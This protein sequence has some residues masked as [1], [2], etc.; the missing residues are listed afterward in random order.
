MKNRFDDRAIAAAFTQVP[1]FIA[2]F[3]VALIAFGLSTEL[4]DKDLITAL[5][6][7]GFGLYTASATL[8][9]ITA[10]VYEGAVL[11]PRFFL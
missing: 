6:V 5:L 1:G 10:G 8:S 3:S 7:V 9:A 4:K 2:A 11:N